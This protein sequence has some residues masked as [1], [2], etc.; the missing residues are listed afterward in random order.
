MDYMLSARAAALTNTL[1]KCNRCNVCTKYALDTI[2]FYRRTCTRC[3]S[4][5]DTE[6]GNSNLLVKIVCGCAYYEKN[7]RCRW[8][9]IVRDKCGTIC[10]PCCPTM[11]KQKVDPQTSTSFIHSKWDY[12]THQSRN[13]SKETHHDYL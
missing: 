4:V 3:L 11:D 8:S 1:A 13:D 7:C 9:L 2:V 12:Q 10:K 6:H 5:H